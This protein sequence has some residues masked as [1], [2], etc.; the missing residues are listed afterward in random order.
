[1]NK[2]IKKHIKFFDFLGIVA[3][4]VI[5][6][7][8]FMFI[9]TN[10][11]QLVKLGF[12]QGLGYNIDFENVSFRNY[13]EIFFKDLRLYD[14]ENNELIVEDKEVHL[15]ID[16][17]SFFN[18]PI[19]KIYF[20]EPKLYIKIKNKKELNILDAILVSSKKKVKNSLIQKITIENANIELKDYSYKTLI[21]KDIVAVNGDIKFYSLNKFVVELKGYTKEKKDAFF[22]YKFI[23]NKDKIKNIFELKNFKLE[24]EFIQYG[25]LDEYITANSGSFDM[26]LEITN[27]NDLYG[28]LILDSDKIN[29]IGNSQNLEINNVKSEVFFLG[30][31]IKGYIN[32]KI[33][34]NELEFLINKEDKNSQ[35][36]I[37]SKN[38]NINDIIE[39]IKFKNKD[40]L[41]DVEG[42]LSYVSLDLNFNGNNLKKTNLYMRSKRI[43]YL[44]NSAENIKGTIFYN[45]G[46][47]GIKDLTTTL[48]LI[49]NNIKSKFDIKLN[50]D[51]I[52]NELIR[53]NYYINKIDSKLDFENLYGE[54]NYDIKNKQININNNTKNFK[55]KFLINENK[56]LLNLNSAGY[57]INF[58]NNIV[59]DLKGNLFLDFNYKKRQ[60]NKLTSDMI[61]KNNLYFDN[62]EIKIRES[63]KLKKYNIET[64]NIIKNNSFVK[65]NGFFINDR[66][67]LYIK[68][69]KLN[70][71]DIYFLKKYPKL[72]FNSIIRGK[73]EGDFYKLQ[74]NGDFFGDGEYIAKLNNIKTKFKLEYSNKLKIKTKSSLS[75]FNY[76]NISLK[77]LKVE[78]DYRDNKL[79]INNI[80][81]RYLKLKGIYD[82]I[83]DNINIEYRVNNYL[84]DNIKE[85]T[86]LDIIGKSINFSGKVKVKNKLDFK[87]KIEETQLLYLNSYNIL[88][89][90]EV[91]LKNNILSFNDISINK[92]KINGKINLATQNIDININIYEDNINTILKNDN[93]KAKIIGESYVIGDFNKIK[94]INKLNFK[95]MYYKGYKLPNVST[96]FSYSAK[97]NKKYIG[98]ID[99]SKLQIIQN[100]YSIL[101]L[102][103]NINFD[104]GN[105]NINSNKNNIE[106]EKINNIFMESQIKGRLGTEFKLKGNIY[107]EFDYRLRLESKKL[108]Y[109]KINFDNILIDMTGDNE[110]VVLNKA[111][112]RY[113][114]NILSGVG[115]YNYNNSKYEFNLDGNDI[116]ISFLNILNIPN[117]KAIGGI[118]DI[119]LKFKNKNQIGSLNIKDFFAKDKYGL[120]DLKNV[121]IESEF[122]ENKIF[123]KT[124]KGLLN[125]G[126]IFVNGE[127]DFPIITLNNNKYEIKFNKY[128]LSY[129]LEKISV[130]D[131]KR[132]NLI[133]DL[134]GNVNESKINSTLNILAGNIYNLSFSDKKVTLSEAKL[135]KFLSLIDVEIAINIKNSITANIEKISV[136]NDI[137]A[138]LDGG[139]ILRI[140]NGNINFIGTITSENGAVTFNDNIFK[141]TDAII[142]FD[143][144]NSYLPNIN[145]SITINAE[146]S[147]S[148]ENIYVSL[149]GR[150]NDL[151]VNMT[152]SSGLNEIEIT[153]LLLFKTTLSDSNASEV[154]KDILNRQFEGQLFN[155]LS[156]ELERIFNI[157]KIKISSPVFSKNEENGNYKFTNDIILGANIELSNPIYKDILSWNLYTEFSQYESGKIND[158]DLWLNYKFNDNVSWKTGIKKRTPGSL[159]DDRISS[160]I[161]L[162]FKY[163]V[164]SFFTFINFLKKSN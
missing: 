130:Y 83:E 142:V 109:K 88:L 141:L 98:N 160:H 156:N 38:L 27:N 112:I 60:I 90:G 117:L 125:S 150:Y 58:L 33:K 123:I 144:P 94:I 115:S 127:I 105:V 119:S 41:K 146:T 100:N 73:I 51:Y 50:S 148:T 99:F 164:D 74:F 2:F 57:K 26:K 102:F 101:N 4:I 49:Q 68:D 59:F 11:T 116:D 63:E 66:Y 84:L 79:Y 143:N 137:E 34:D 3:L 15:Y 147:V 75:F 20:K 85:L 140:T 163:K 25:L 133:I 162:D 56:F 6:V 152:S 111:L 155:P 22:G 121:T 159:E 62:L 72:K 65:I 134:S 78:L 103:G 70:A 53:T 104:T 17:K 16:Y 1:M 82:L 158:Y 67:T 131:K 149:N 151:K 132:F 36:K 12:K 96:E 93:L 54:I 42:I 92:N 95:N 71:K 145:P 31:D 113:N 139:G 114:D 29:Y 126:E 9:R 138:D 107:K 161:D 86:K 89:N 8:L 136:I 35:I 80:E 118:A 81:N 153:S 32:G 44:E 135:E 21:K 91:E 47:F 129:I 106:F 87:L 5:F 14:K 48:E 76:D 23:K 28:N 37:I 18:S 13:N 46:I 55:F 157:N 52:S 108:E 120:I 30:Q 69:S 19:K 45:N 122:K 64:L 77:E 124:I 97:K 40:M 43:N 61:I 39:E 110:K 10:F 128:N 7:F 154:V 24:K